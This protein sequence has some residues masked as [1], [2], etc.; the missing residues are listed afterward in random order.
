MSF[1]EAVR[2]LRGSRSQKDLGALV[3]V[4]SQTI[5]RYETGRSNPEPETRMALYKLAE[6]EGR[7]DLL[8]ALGGSTF[9]VQSHPQITTT[10]VPD[11]YTADEQ[12]WVDKLIFILRSNHE[13]SIHAVCSNLVAFENLVELANDTD[14][15]IA[16]QKKRA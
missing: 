10:T 2:L 7:T 5:S 13:V 1:G 3:R 14:S 16:S 4:D 11:G 6:S 9:V 12:Q 8:G 15:S